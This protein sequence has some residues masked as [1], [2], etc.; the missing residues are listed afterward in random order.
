MGQFQLQTMKALHTNT[1][2]TYVTA[3]GVAVTIIGWFSAPAV[4]DY[5]HNYWKS[6]PT[7]T[8]TK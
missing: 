4:A 6:P 3:L 2:A 5:I 1:K 8:R 7:I